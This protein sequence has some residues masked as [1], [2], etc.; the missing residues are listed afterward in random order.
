MKSEP[1]YF[2]ELRKARDE[3]AWGPIAL[4]GENDESGSPPHESVVHY[5]HVSD[6]D[7]RQDKGAVVSMLEAHMISSIRRDH[8]SLTRV[9]IQSDNAS[10]YQN[11]GIRP[12]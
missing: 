4:L 8:P 6:G 10:S 7:N 2:R 9:T 3:L 11:R 12:H 5:D 1:I